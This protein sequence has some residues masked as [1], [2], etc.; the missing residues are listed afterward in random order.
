M[1]TLTPSNVKKRIIFRLIGNKSVGM[2]HIYRSLSLAQQMQGEQILFV[3]DA[4]SES[5]VRL[6]LDPNYWLGVYDVESILTRI[7]EL[8]PDVV[9]NDILD[10]SVSDIEYLRR[11][12]IKV[13]N[14]EDLGTGATASNLTINELYDDPQLIGGNVLWGYHYFFVRDEFTSVEPNN[15]NPKVSQILLTF[16]V[17]TNI[18]CRNIFAKKY[19]RFADTMISS[20]I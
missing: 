18:V 15:F 20:Y 12:G 7:V 14:F 8:E 3:C 6:V 11:N 1:S 13:V 5:F 4:D 2:G 16:G 10:T 17:R 19:S 9:I